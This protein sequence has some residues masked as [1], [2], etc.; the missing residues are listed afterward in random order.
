MYV[1]ELTLEKLRVILIVQTGWVVMM[2]QALPLTFNATVSNANAFIISP[3]A[4][5]LF[6]C[7]IYGNYNIWYHYIISLNSFVN[8]TQYQQTAPFKYN[9][10]PDI[11]IAALTKILDIIPTCITMC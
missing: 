8:N 7:V 2:R 11:K 6:S 1:S 5:S 10:S 9:N 3:D 4:I